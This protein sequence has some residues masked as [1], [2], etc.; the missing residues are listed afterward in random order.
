MQRK[1]LPNPGLSALLPLPSS[2]V[3]ATHPSAL[4]TNQPMLG[5]CHRPHLGSCAHPSAKDSQVQGTSKQTIDQA[6]PPYVSPLRLCRAT[7]PT[8]PGSQLSLQTSINPPHFY[9]LL[10][11]HRSPPSTHADTG[12]S[13][14]T[15]KEPH[16][17]LGALRTHRHSYSGP[18]PQ[19]GREMTGLGWGLSRGVGMQATSPLLRQCIKSWVLSHVFPSPSRKKESSL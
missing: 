2:S 1:S 7:N 5:L 14:P 12:R 18:T 4:I 16:L 9:V 15:A 19:G 17:I 8:T 3:W 10:H 11:H 6:G 13:P